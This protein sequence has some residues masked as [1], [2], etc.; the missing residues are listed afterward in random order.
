MLN[1]K[2]TLIKV[3]NRDNGSVGYTIPDL[4]KLT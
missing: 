4:G 1:D 3:T 2:N